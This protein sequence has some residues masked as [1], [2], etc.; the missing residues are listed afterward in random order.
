M[1]LAAAEIQ[2]KN[3]IFIIT[4][5]YIRCV[6][7]DP[8][9][10]FLAAGLGFGEFFTLLLLSEGSLVRQ[11]LITFYDAWPLEHI[12]LSQTPAR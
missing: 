8:W 5:I 10:S 3:S 9:N 4:E 7:L 1:D 6:A 2:A 11:P 12:I